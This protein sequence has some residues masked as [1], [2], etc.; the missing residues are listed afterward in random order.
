MTKYDVPDSES[1]VEKKLYQHGTLA[2]L[3]PGLLRGT[4]TMQQ[5]LQHGDTGIGTGEGLDGELIILDGKPYQV[6]GDGG[7]NI[8]SGDFTMP[9]ANIHR[10]HYRDLMDLS[11]LPMDEAYQRIAEKVCA[12]NTFYSIRM[13]G[14][15]SS[16]TTRAVRKS[17]PPYHTL[18]ETAEEQHVFKAE[19]IQGT[20]V[21]YYSPE[22]FHG[23]TVSGFHSH[24]LADD[25]TLGGHILDFSVAK[26]HVKV[27]MFDTFEQHLPVDDDEYMQHDFSADDVGSAITRAEG[28]TKK[29]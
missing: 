28:Q 26:V 5:L 23:P 16:M 27:Q 21:G 17:E 9:F 7:V 24:F 13:S 29:D 14:L 1:T 20:L 2:L 15:F 11:D 4:L 3:V 18:V 19:N 25:H 6:N 10:A 12:E 22:V 8:V